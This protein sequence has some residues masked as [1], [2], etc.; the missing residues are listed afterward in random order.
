[1]ENSRQVQ[2]RYPRTNLSFN[3]PTTEPFPFSSEKKKKKDLW[4]YFLAGE[5][6]TTLG[7]VPLRRRLRGLRGAGSRFTFPP[8]K[9]VFPLAETQTGI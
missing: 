4:S 2:L 3:S 8:P 5:T 7:N 6:R 9:H 1:M